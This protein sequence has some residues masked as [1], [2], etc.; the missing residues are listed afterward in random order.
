VPALIERLMVSNKSEIKQIVGSIIKLAEGGEKW[1]I[2][3]VAARVWPVP[4]GRTIAF[5]LPEIR[6]AADGEAAI[7]AI[8][9]ACGAGRLTPAEAKTLSDIVARKVETTHMRVLEERMQVLE[10]AQ[11]RQIK[12]YQKIG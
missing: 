1:A 8:L 12:S 3:A 5:D 4:S 7:G 6:T 2:E 9:A 10:Q 11:P